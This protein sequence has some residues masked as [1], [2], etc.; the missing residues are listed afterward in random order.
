MGVSLI[1]AGCVSTPEAGPGASQLQLSEIQ[2]DL[3]TASQELRDHYSEAGWS[4]PMSGA[5]FGALASMLLDGRREDQ[6]PTPVETYLASF[7]GSDAS[8]F[9]IHARLEADLATATTL[10]AD[11]ASAARSVALSGSIE[12]RGLAGDLGATEDAIAAISRADDFFD[13]TIIAVSERLEPE[14][15][16]ALRSRHQA[17]RHE[18][19]RLGTAA[20]VIADRRR[21]LRG[22]TLS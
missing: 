7:A 6:G 12:T 1:L 8:A 18:F 2:S 13:T 14:Q 9:Q 17:L 3:R 20:D 10:A 11:V 22:G 19:D 21:A 15:L 4:A 16:S 5:S